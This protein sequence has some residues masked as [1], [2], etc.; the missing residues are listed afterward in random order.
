MTVAKALQF[1]SFEDYLS[2]PPPS[3]PEGHFEYWDG[4]LVEVMTESLLNDSIAKYLMFLLMNM[5][6]PLELICI[7]S[8]EVVVP[9]RPRTR[10]PD[11]VV[12]DE[13]HLELLKKRSTITDKMPPPRL[14][15]EVASPGDE[16]SDNYQRD[17]VQK[18]QQYAAI[19]VRE[20]WIIDPDRDVIK[21]GLLVDGS[22]QF[23]DFTGNSRIASLTFPA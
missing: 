8:C 10:F 22:Y 20:Y 15:V 21:V 9:G 14:L 6:T 23:Q 18:P 19:G 7:H 1:R 12:L 3:L 2:V 17:Y 5:G 4:E 11:L 13:A 16:D